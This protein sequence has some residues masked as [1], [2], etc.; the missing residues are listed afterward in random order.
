L[1]KLEIQLHSLF[2]REE[3]SE[4][5]AQPNLIIHHGQFVD[6]ESDYDEGTLSLSLFN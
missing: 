5:Q 2:G 1:K 6:L 3:I 4:R